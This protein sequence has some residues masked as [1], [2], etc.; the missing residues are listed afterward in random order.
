M[1]VATKKPATVQS[2]VYVTNEIYEIW[3][4][5]PV[6]LGRI[7]KRNGYWYTQDQMRFIS[8]RDAMRYLISKAGHQVQVPEVQ[9]PER[10]KEVL[11]I[12]QERRT[13]VLQKKITTRPVRKEVVR[14]N[15]DAAVNSPIVEINQNHPK[16]QEFLDYLDYSARKKQK[17]H[18]DTHK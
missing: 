16:F 15:A 2:P 1:K 3:Y 8:S 13:P 12:Q 17:P 4:A 14:S 11:P 7:H 6:S 5:E 10:R 9:T 18:L